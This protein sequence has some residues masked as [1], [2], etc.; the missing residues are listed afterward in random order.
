MQLWKAALF[1]T[2]M[3][4]V[5]SS[6]LP[7]QP[8]KK[9]HFNSGSFPP[10]IHVQN[11]LIFFLCKKIVKH[12]HPQRH[13]LHKSKAKDKPNVC[14]WCFEPAAAEY[15][16]VMQLQSAPSLQKWLCAVPWINCPASIPNNSHSSYVILNSFGVLGQKQLHLAVN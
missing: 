7:L 5:L 8:L 16:H 12:L 13:L 1:S 11:E 15:F 2:E 14:L 4:L 3:Q 10:Q 6:R 9:D